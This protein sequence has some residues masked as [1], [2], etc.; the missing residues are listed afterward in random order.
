MK[1]VKR[2]VSILIFSILMLLTPILTILANAYINILP[3]WG[4]GSILTKMTVSDILILVIYPVAAVSIF[5]VTKAGW[6]TFIASAA[7]LFAYNIIAYIRN[8]MISLMGVIIFNLLLFV[9]AGL[10]FRKHI[11][12][13]Y[14]NPRLRWWEQ[15]SRFDIDLGVS[16]EYSESYELG[17]LEDISMGGCFI[18]ISEK[19]TVGT[20]YPLKISL[21]NEL[22]ISI[23]GRIM[24]SIADDCSLP[25]YGVMFSNLSNTEKDGL[26]N[27]IAGLYKLGIGENPSEK[28]GA[29]QRAYDRYSVNISVSFRYKGEILPARLINFSSTGACLETM[30]EMEMG[31][32]CGFYC[33]L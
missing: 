3:L 4:A 28:S 8:P 11:I 20:V 22:S 14:F 5:M 23:R 7:C 12:A 29:E 30:M 2:P 21:G 31:E 17:Y 1:S 18:R 19:V 24:R 16:L 26:S 25:G 27:M 13:P 10:F 6:W 33:T 32:F 15:A 9:V